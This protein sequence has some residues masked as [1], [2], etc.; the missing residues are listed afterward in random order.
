M[1]EHGGEWPYQ[2]SGFLFVPEPDFALTVLT[3]GVSPGYA[4]IWL[5]RLG[6]ATV[7]RVGNPRP[8][9]GVSRPRAWRG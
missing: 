4:T 5:R 8:C 1:V 6:A 9:P 7:C 3:N 2:N